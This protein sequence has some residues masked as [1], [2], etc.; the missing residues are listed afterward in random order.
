MTYTYIAH[1]LPHQEQ[2]LD[3]IV[4]RFNAVD[5]ESKLFVVFDNCPEEYPNKYPDL[6][7]LVN[8]KN[9]WGFPTSVN[10]AVAGSKLHTYITDRDLII[11]P[12]VF[13]K[14]LFDIKDLKDVLFGTFVY[15]VKDE[16]WNKL[17][18]FDTLFRE[19]MYLIDF[20]HR[21]KLAGYKIGV[22]EE[23][24]KS[25][26]G[27][28][29]EPSFDTLKFGTKWDI[30]DSVAI[31]DFWSYLQTAKYEWSEDMVCK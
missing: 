3:N 24:I 27:I 11:L 30:P 12:D 6:D 16:V 21:A 2:R 10:K 26:I 15:F 23:I 19:Q 31:Q 9:T 8:P 20:A 13:F 22:A 1:I 7:R 5:P 14:P 4:S 28:N 25:E 17:G 29:G 18:G